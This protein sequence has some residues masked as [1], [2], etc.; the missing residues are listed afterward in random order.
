MKVSVT[1]GHTIDTTNPFGSI[2]M[3]LIDNICWQAHFSRHVEC[4][5]SCAQ[6]SFHLGEQTATRKSTNIKTTC[7]EC[8]TLLHQ[9]T[10]L[11]EMQVNMRRFC[12]IKEENL[13]SAMTPYALQA[14]EQMLF[15]SFSFRFIETYFFLTRYVTKCTMLWRKENWKSSNLI[16]N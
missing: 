8:I 16:R 7:N 3:I 2:F 1:K 12:F 4:S 5:F 6:T 10:N 9:I 13:F 11:W 15:F 14:N